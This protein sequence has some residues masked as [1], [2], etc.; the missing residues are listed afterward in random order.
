MGEERCFVMML[1]RGNDVGQA[2]PIQ[3]RWL[4]GSFVDVSGEGESQIAMGTFRI[5]HKGPEI[6]SESEM[7]HVGS[8]DFA[9]LLDHTDHLWKYYETLTCGHPSLASLHKANAVFLHICQLLLFKTVHF[10]MDYISTYKF[11]SL[12]DTPVLAV[13]GTQLTSSANMYFWTVFSQVVAF[14][15]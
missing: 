2:G 1:E 4:S 7:T 14:K 3:S 15:W 13:L 11:N 12:R 9:G 6:P 8:M 10:L 5:K